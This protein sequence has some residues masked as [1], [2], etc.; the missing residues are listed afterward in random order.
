MVSSCCEQQQETLSWEVLFLEAMGAHRPPLLSRAALDSVLQVTLKC[1]VMV[2]ISQL[3]PGC[4]LQGLGA[5]LAGSD[6]VVVPGTEWIHV[7][8]LHS[9]FPVFCWCT[10][11]TGITHSPCRQTHQVPLSYG[12]VSRMEMLLLLYLNIPVHVRGRMHLLCTYSPLRCHSVLVPS[13]FPKLSFHSC[14]SHPWT[15]CL[16]CQK[17]CLCPSC[18]RQLPASENSK[19]CPSP[20]QWN[21]VVSKSHWPECC[22][23]R[24]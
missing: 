2:W 10:V 8:V 16:P 3:F 12:S 15:S 20:E 14:F 1:C 13:A 18:G 21:F 7:L 17:G 11:E 23:K 19:S 24:V 22:S 6:L 5:V 9:S 4:F